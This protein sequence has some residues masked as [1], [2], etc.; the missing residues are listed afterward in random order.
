M[1][2]LDNFE[3]KKKNSYLLLE[4]GTLFQGYSFGADID[5]DGEIGKLKDYFLL[6]LI[7]T[8]LR[9][10]FKKVFSTGMTGYV[11]SLSDPSYKNQ[12]LMLTYPLVGNY[13]VPGG[14][15]DEYALK[16]YFESDKIHATGLIVEEYCEKYN[17]WNAEKSLGQWLIEENVPAICGIDTRK[18]T[19]ILREKGSMLAKVSYFIHL[20]LTISWFIQILIH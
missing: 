13:G 19:K 5:R 14:A 10:K 9:L 17:H 8:N 3:E 7:N 2:K 20:K 6:S 12:F 15:N 1:V 16:K 11:E 4:D 18:L